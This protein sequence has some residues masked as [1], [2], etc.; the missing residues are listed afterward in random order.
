VEDISTITPRS[1]PGIWVEYSKA[2]V[3]VR[4][5]LGRDGDTAIS[6]S[7]RTWIRYVQSVLVGLINCRTLRAAEKDDE[8]M[9]I[10]CCLP[11]VGQINAYRIERRSERRQGPQGSGNGNSHGKPPGGTLVCTASAAASQRGILL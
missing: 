8:A 11:E 3:R 9:R 10:H 4:F 5:T 6:A 2:T 1:S 7:K